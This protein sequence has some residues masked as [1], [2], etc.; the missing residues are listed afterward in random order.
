VPGSTSDLVQLLKE[1]TLPSLS[2]SGYQSIIILSLRMFHSVILMMATA[3]L[4]PAPVA[5]G[6]FPRALSVSDQQAERELAR[7]QEEE[8]KHPEFMHSESRSLANTCDEDYVSTSCILIFFGGDDFID[9]YEGCGALFKE[10][11][12][13]C[14]HP[15]F[16]NI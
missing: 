6:L 2:S 3:L 7:F 15:T 12:E 4:L 10:T 14:D 5:G 13:F 11:D 8:C 9:A 1:I 16:G